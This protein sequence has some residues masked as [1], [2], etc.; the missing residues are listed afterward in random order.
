MNNVS[1]AFSVLQ[2]MYAKHGIATYPLKPDKT[3][4]ISH[5]GRIGAPGSAQIAMKFPNAT[6]AGFVAGIRSRVT[7]VDIDSQDERLVADMQRRYGETPLHVIT[8][9]GGKHLYYRH[10]GEA[11]NIRPLPGIEVDILGDGNVVAAL[12]VVPKGQYAIERG[13]IDDLDR[14]PRMRTEV[15]RQGPTAI[16]K[17]Q[18]NNALFKY[19]RSIVDSCDD[20]DQLVDVAYH[21]A[22]RS[23][24]EP[25]PDAEVL[26][27]C[28]SAWNYRGGRV[29]VGGHIVE[30]SMYL[31]L[32]ADPHVLALFSALSTENGPAANFMVANGF[33]KAS[34]WSRRLVPA[35]RKKLL[36]LGAIRCIREHRKGAAAL[37]CWAL[38]P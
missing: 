26:K 25:L 5:Y 37:Y 13:S 12:S 22:E 18:R 11:R 19:C 21:W 15:P 38:P 31:R 20:L 9:S 34:G 33:G 23:L 27:T 7:V 29:R 24:P 30:M 1:G 8:P 35:A 16:Q 10:G 14:L 17:G 6:A 32:K 3:P 2:A 36:D 4:A 28:T